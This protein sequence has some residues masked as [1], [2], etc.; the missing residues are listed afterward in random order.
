MG[1]VY[2]SARTFCDGPCYDLGS[3]LEVFLPKAVQLQQL[4]GT[5]S[6]SSGGCCMVVRDS[7]P[8]LP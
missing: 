2:A 7:F 5:V 3:I 8:S 6:Y 4:V 1:L